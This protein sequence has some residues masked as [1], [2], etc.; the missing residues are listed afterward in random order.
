MRGYG[1]V[2]PIIF[3]LLFIIFNNIP[4]ITYLLLKPKNNNN[5]KHFV[6]NNLIKLFTH[7]DIDFFFFIKAMTVNLQLQ[8][9]HNRV[10]LHLTML[11]RHLFIMSKSKI[12][13]Y[14]NVA[15]F[16]SSKQSSDDDLKSLQQKKKHVSM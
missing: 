9:F 2:P 16:N 11:L 13:N 12:I 1:D 10:F 7:F 6:W 14:F 4:F 3:L 5:V 15:N 8:L